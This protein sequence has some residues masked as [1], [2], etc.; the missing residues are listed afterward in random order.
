MESIRVELEELASSR[1][2]LAKRATFKLATRRVAAAKKGERAK[3]TGTEQRRR[4]KI[5][6]RGILGSIETVVSFHAQHLLK[7]WSHYE[8]HDLFTGTVGDIS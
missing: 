7:G 6:H 2:R 5:L 3:Q 8:Y 4:S 1:V